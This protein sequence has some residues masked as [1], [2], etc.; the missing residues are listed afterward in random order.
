MTRDIIVVSRRYYFGINITSFI[1]EAPAL[2]TAEELFYIATFRKD[3][4]T[5][6]ISDQ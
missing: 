5:F 6:P 4:I 1:G 3:E 2:R